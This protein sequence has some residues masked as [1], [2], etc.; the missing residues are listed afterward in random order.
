VKRESISIRGLCG[1]PEINPGDNLSGIIAKALHDSGAVENREVRPHGSGVILVV[2][3]KVVSKAEGCLVRLADVSPSHRARMWAEEH[4]KDAR[5]IEVVLRQARR[6]VRMDR[7][8]L[9]VETSH[10]FVCANGGVDVS[11]APTGC[12]V[13]LPKDPDQSARRLRQELETAFGRQFGVIISD[14]FGRPWRQGLTNVALGVSGLSPFIDYRGQLDSYGR[15]LQ[16]TFLAVADEL[17]SAG[18]LVMGKTSGIPA[19]V[20]EGFAYQPAEGSG[21]AL[22][23]PGD[24][25]LFR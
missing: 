19:A 11:N 6:I 18:E 16:A 13:T 4:R 20:I 5:L 23:R 17:A 24:E 9:I 25:D 1:I 10:G 3:Q 2:A 12:V 21:Q 22:I 14:T 7:G 15:E 8:V